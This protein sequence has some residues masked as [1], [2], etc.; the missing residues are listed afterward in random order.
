MVLVVVVRGIVTPSFDVR[1]RHR[2]GGYCE[3]R[4]RRSCAFALG[5][6]ALARRACVVCGRHRNTICIA[7]VGV[8]RRKLGVL[9]AELLSCAIATVQR[10]KENDRIKSSQDSRS[11]TNK[12]PER[13]LSKRKVSTTRSDLQAKVCEIKRWEREKGYLI[14]YGADC[15]DQAIL[16]GMGN[17]QI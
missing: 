7:A 10:S 14:R 1:M 4:E 3:Y 13:L 8:V 6:T 17:E 2:D 16:D 9:T 15:S 12:G 5:L 11:A